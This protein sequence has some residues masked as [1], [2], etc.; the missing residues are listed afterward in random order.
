MLWIQ[1]Y[2]NIHFYFSLS[3]S[4]SLSPLIYQCNLRC[5]I[6]MFYFPGWGFESF[7]FKLGQ[8]SWYHFPVGVMVELLS[9][10]LG[11]FISSWLMMQHWLGESRDAK[12]KI[13]MRPLPMNKVPSCF[14]PSLSVSGGSIPAA[15][16]Q[17]CCIICIVSYVR[18]CESVSYR[19]IWY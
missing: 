2:F 18:S 14:D 13:I 4:L 15:S 12:V 3:L 19:I 8:R 7:A 1:S 10:S 6:R 5:M 17:V 9:I 16:D 11:I